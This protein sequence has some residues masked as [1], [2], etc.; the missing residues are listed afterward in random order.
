MTSYV[1]DLRRELTTAGI[2][3]R[4]RD[5]IVAEFAD[6][7]S[8]DPHADLGSPRELAGEFADELGTSRARRGAFAVF[9]ALALVGTM[10]ATFLVE[11]FGPVNHQTAAADI[12]GG[13][14]LVAAQ[15]AFAVGVL[16]VLRAGQRRRAFALPRAEAVVLVR[17]SA[18]ALGAGV[19]TMIALAVAALVL[20]YVGHT[21]ARAH[22]LVIAAAGG[23]A[24]L[25]ALPYVISAARLLPS[26]PGDAG[27]IFEDIGRFTP[28]TLRGRPWL[29]A[30]LVAAGLG[31]VTAAA[32]VIQSDPYDGILR[33]FAEATACLAGFALLGPFLGLW[34]PRAAPNT[35]E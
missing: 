32:G 21:G 9:A 29:V 5:R 28:T 10:L 2:R 7:L 14:L 12:A 1:Q 6:H 27:D 30:L 15:V 11:Q 20:R 19:V 3:G 24:L 35:P 8:C 26:K 23:A 4:R 34:T 16:A 33:G 22:A 13:I 25:A 18:V 31:L 17:R